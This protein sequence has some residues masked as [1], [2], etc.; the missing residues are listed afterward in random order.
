MI[1]L[2]PKGESITGPFLSLCFNSRFMQQMFQ[3]IRSGSTVP[4][5]TCR[6][7]K[8]IAIPV[9]SLAEQI[10]IVGNLQLLSAETQRLESIYR[11]ELAAL[12]ELKQSILQKA[13]TG[14]LTA[15]DLD[16]GAAA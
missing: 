11:R 16:E 10:R 13:F 7:V 4:H 3:A 5:L 14:E 6:A 9:P 2:T 15:K 1:V 12:A 8:E